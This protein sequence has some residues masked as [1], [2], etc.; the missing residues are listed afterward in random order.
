MKKLSLA[1]LGV[2]ALAAIALAPSAAMADCQVGNCWGAV[3]YGPRGS[4]A[5][6]V[7][8]PARGIAERVAQ[9]R[10][11]GRCNHVLTF[12]NSCGAYA[13]GPSARGYYGWGNAMSGPAA[14]ARALQECNA[15]GP[16]CEVRVWGCTTR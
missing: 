1:L 7:N 12:Q 3:A 11:G 5:Y 4:W 13:S 14:Q 9:N 6:A 2:S 10:C 15:R 8:Y 16:Y